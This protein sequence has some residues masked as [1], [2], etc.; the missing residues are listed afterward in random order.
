MISVSEELERADSD[1]DWTRP[2]VA[3]GGLYWFI[4]ARVDTGRETG[5]HRVGFKPHP[6]DPDALVLFYDGQ[7]TTISRAD[8][9]AVA[10][11]LS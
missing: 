3:Q 11:L 6:D 7:N 1:A 9:R 2:H 8:L 10:A 4:R 5:W